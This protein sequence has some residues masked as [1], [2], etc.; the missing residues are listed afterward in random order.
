MKWFAT[1]RARSGVVVNNLLLYVSGGF[2]FANHRNEFL[3]D[4]G[5]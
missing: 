4:P 3:F 1:L 5:I 2:A